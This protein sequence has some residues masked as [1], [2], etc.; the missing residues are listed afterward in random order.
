MLT[1]VKLG[2]VELDAVVM[3]SIVLLV[4]LMPLSSYFTQCMSL[5]VSSRLEVGRKAGDLAL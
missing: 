5:D 2:V 4:R 1:F 3:P